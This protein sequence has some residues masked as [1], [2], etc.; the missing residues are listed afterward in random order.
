MKIEKINELCWGG[1]GGGQS[2]QITSLSTELKNMNEKFSSDHSTAESIFTIN[3]HTIWY[4]VSCFS[5]VFNFEVR[6]V[7]KTINTFCVSVLTLF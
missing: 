7:N 1:G 4:E 6:L 2:S 3:V 5:K